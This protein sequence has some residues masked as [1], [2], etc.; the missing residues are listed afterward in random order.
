ML[1]PVAWRHV[2]DIKSNGND[3]NEIHDGRRYDHAMNTKILTLRMN[4]R[5]IWALKTIGDN[6]GGLKSHL[7]IILY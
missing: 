7:M 2:Y 6:G 5:F 4:R 3:V 1:Q